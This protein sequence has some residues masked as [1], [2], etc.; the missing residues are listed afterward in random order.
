MSEE[1]IEVKT[2]FTKEELESIT[3]DIKDAEAKLKPESKSDINIEAIKNQIKAE[4]L[5]EF[6]K[7]Q[8]AEAAKVA[9][10]AERQRQ[11]DALKTIDDLKAKVDEM[12]ESKAVVD[13]KSPFSKEQSIDNM[14]PEQY[15]EVDRASKEAAMSYFKNRS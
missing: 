1:N 5:A 11:A 10:A 4:A 13:N 9:E 12:S 3:K 6:K 2:T 7:Q 8:E 15:R 14:T